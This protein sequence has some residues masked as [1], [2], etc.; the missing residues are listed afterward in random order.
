MFISIGKAS[1][2]MGVSVTTLR[3]W[4]RS[5]KFCCDHKTAGGHRRYSVTKIKEFIGEAINNMSKK[6]VAY[7]R[8]SSHD[9]KEDLQRQVDRLDKYCSIHFHSYEVINDLGSG[10]NYKKKGLKRLLKLILSGQLSKIILTHK[11][12]LLRFGSELIFQICHF[13][14]VEIEILE[15]KKNLSD[16]QILAFDVLEM[17]TVFSARLYGK[18]SHQNKKVLTA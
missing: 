5:S 12:R 10:M 13:F 2:M 3:R 1:I 11:D 15:E 9:Q 16:E 17:I 18:R 14:G 4:E 6:V 7:A 8:V